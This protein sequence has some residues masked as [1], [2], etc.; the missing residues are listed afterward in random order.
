M[1]FN[2]KDYTTTKKEKSRHISVFEFFKILQLEAIVADIRGKIY[3]RAKDKNYWKKVF[4]SK[5]KTVLDIAERNKVNNIPLPSIFTD[6]EMYEEYQ[7]EILGEGGYPSFIYKNKDDEQNQ[8]YYDSINYY[9]RGSSIACKYLNEIR[10]G[11]VESYK[12]Y[13]SVVS[14]K[15]ENN[16]K[17]ELPIKDVTRI[18]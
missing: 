6:S 9:Q 1:E 2:E 18:L 13:S 8:G 12:P 16:L 15:L 5:K 7:K 4:E 10:F 11:V 14:V 3:Y 17:L